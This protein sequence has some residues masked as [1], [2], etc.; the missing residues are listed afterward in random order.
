MHARRRSAGMSLIEL[1]IAMAIIGIVMAVAIPSYQAWMQNTRIRTVAESILNGMQLA[2]A[3]AVRRNTNVGFYLMTTLDSSCADSSTDS[4]WLV[5]I[6]DP[7]GLC[8]SAVSDA[9]APQILQKR[10][11]QEDAAGVVTLTTLPS[12]PAPATSVIFTPL[13]R[14]TNSTSDLTQVDLVATNPVSGSRP[15]RIVIGAGGTIKMCDP[16]LTGSDPRRC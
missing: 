3:E 10:S 13:G 12:V 5:S 6:Q 14:T 2:R 16:L 9:V 1:V 7:N 4:N 15:L 8:D 11:S